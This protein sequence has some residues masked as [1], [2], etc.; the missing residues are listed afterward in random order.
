[1]ANAGPGTAGSQFF[2]LLEPTP[3]LDGRHAV[4]GQCE[5]IDTIRRISLAPTSPEDDPTPP[6]TIEQLS[7]QWRAQGA[8]DAP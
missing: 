1:M 6:V 8:K 5:D 3:H 4:F 2:I 7:W